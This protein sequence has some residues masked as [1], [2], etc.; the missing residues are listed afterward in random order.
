MLGR[1]LVALV[2]AVSLAAC[3]DGAVSR[4]LDP[5][6]SPSFSNGEKTG[7]C[8]YQLGVDGTQVYPGPGGDAAVTAPNGMVVTRIAVKA[9]QTCVFTPETVTGT[10]TIAVEGAPCYVVTGLGSGAVTVARV[11]DGPACKDISHVEFTAAAK[12]TTGL[13]QICT[14]LSPMVPPT[15]QLAPFRFMVAGLDVAVADGACSSPLELPAG[16]FVITEAPNALAIGLWAA[17]TVPDDRLVGFVATQSATV[18]VVAGST[19]V[20]TITNLFVPPDPGPD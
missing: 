3:S 12:P 10:Y 11:G 16:A 20:V 6:A 14:L 18:M 9:G 2:A 13:L 8:F 5:T 17:T 1:V 4:S 15:Q 19:T 7:H